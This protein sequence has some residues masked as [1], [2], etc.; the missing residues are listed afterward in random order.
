MS[1]TKA[2]NETA[3]KE[4]P[5]PEQG[6]KVHYFRDAVVQGR[7]IPAGL[8]VRV[9]A[10]GVKAFVLNYRIGGVE[11]RY[12]IG[13]W[14]DW[15][16]LDAVKEA[17]QLRQKIDRGEDPMSARTAK[18]AEPTKTVADV[19]DLFLARHKLRRP[20]QYEDS[21]KR[22]VKPAIGALPIGD[23]KRRHVIDMLDSIED[24][25]GPVMATRALAYLRSALNW[26]ATRDDEFVVPIVKGMAR[27]NSSDRARTRILNDDEIRV[28][29]P[30]FGQVGNFGAACR[31]MLLTGTR[32][33]EATGMLW[34]ELDGETWTIPAARYKTAKDHAVPLSAVARAIIAAQPDAGPRVFPGQRGTLLSHGGHG[35]AAIDKAAPG[36]A[37]WTVHD[38]RRTAR[39]LMSRAGVRPDIAERVLGHAIQGVGGV[40]DRHAYLDEKRNAVERLAELVDRILNPAEVSSLAEKRQALRA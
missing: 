4:L 2:F 5:I 25:S 1:E 35:K 26:Y 30:A 27:S 3:V 7:R 39:S 40:Y 19:L 6:N 28:L 38:I 11:R 33:A 8:G 10:A 20:G 23:L 16:A 21:F 15:S 36:L 13:K 22:L 31:I 14:P 32:K 37:P 17:R 18:P 12:T 34:S 29:W 9:T 24:D